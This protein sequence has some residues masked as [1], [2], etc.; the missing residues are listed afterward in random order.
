VRRD[1]RLG[2]TVEMFG[3]FQ[4]RPLTIRRSTGSLTPFVMSWMMYPRSSVIAVVDV[5][6]FPEL[7]ATAMPASVKCC[8][9]DDDANVCQYPGG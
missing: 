8:Q 7:T 9:D 4:R 5:L 2:S 1:R 6:E 3:Y